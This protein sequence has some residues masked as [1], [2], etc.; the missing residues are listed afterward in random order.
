MD[1]AE[2]PPDGDE[3]R[4]VEDVDPADA[5][6]ALGN[7][8]RVEILQAFR[9]HHLANPTVSAAAFSTLR[10]AVGM[11]DSGQFRYHLE[12]LRGTFV[13]KCDE[14]YRLTYAGSKVIDAI[15]AGTYTGRT[16][17]GPVALDSSCSRCGTAARAHY[18]DGVLEVTCEHDHPLFYWSVPPN[19]AVEPS[20]EELVELATTLAVQSYELVANGTCS[21]CYSGVEPTVRTVET[22]DGDRSV[23]FHARC[24]ACAAGWDAPVGF[25]L[26]GHPEVESLY[27]RQGR[28]ISDRYWW[29]LEV[30]DRTEIEILEEDPLRV[31]LSVTVGETPV[32]AM[33]DESARVLDIDCPANVG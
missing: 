24:G 23:R 4:A 17:L 21:E 26:L 27:Q 12:Q 16:R 10:K 30:V 9:E 20:L 19:A 29:E 5:F 2:I 15:I 13:E 11:K 32:R 22:D 33:V 3:A 25:V 18:R 28:P 7:S 14:G 6:A 8:T 1:D 31:R